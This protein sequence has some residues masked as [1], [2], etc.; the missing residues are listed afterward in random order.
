MA[1]CDDTFYSLWF[2]GQSTEME[3]ILCK[4]TKS[5]KL[6]SQSNSNFMNLILKCELISPQTVSSMDYKRGVFWDSFSY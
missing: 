2:C 6:S 3:S 4:V 5:H 1:S